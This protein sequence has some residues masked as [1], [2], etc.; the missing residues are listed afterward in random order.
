M[1]SQLREGE[2]HYDELAAL[3][4]IAALSASGSD[5]GALIEDILR[6]VGDLLHADNVLLFTLDEDEK[7]L[8]FYDA[9]SKA[10]RKF[11]ARA[12][13][14]IARVL[15]SRTGELL[16]DLHG[17][18]EGDEELRIMTGARELLA[19]P[20]YS[21]DA[22]LGVLAAIDSRRNAFTEEDL[23]VLSL[24]ADRVAMTMENARLLTTLQRQV[25]ELEG[26]QRLS[27]LLITGDSLEAVV[28]DSIRIF[29]DL[30][31]CEQIAILLY[32][33][34]SDTLVAHEP[35]IGITEEQLTELRVSMSEPS[36]V[37]T[38]FRTNTAL[39]SNDPANDAWVSRRFQELLGMETL[40]VVPL[41]T[42][43]KPLGV[44]KAINSEKGYFSEED[45][46]FGALLGRQVGTILEANL[47][48]ARERALVRKLKE[49]DRTKS[50]FV[51][52]LAHELKGPM[53]TVLGF[54]HTLRQQWDQVDAEKRDRVLEII[55]K[56]VGRL[57]R[58]VND[59]L[60]VA[61]MEAGTLRY[62]LE[63]VSLQEVV[64]SVLMVH[65]SLQSDHAVLDEVPPE[66]P[67]VMADKDRI[68][69]VVIN[70][71][72]NA[73]RYSPERTRV[74]V[75]AEEV[76]EGDARRYVR[77]AVTDEGIGIAPQD[78]ERIFTKFAMLPKPGWTQKG[79]GLGLFITKGIVEA[80]GGHIW[81]ES[82]VGRGSTFYVTLRVAED[83]AS[84]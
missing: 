25:R 6:I 24:V 2:R 26:L 48:R 50:E 36:M 56:E 71:L 8:T 60:D 82:E 81:V 32:D 66:I 53:T 40:L 14:V 3:Y 12:S 42:G 11:P 17:G 52:M 4:Q 84:S 47:A 75:T 55:E 79:T 77:L 20:L 33:E 30:I 18:E 58:L 49:A 45:L 74:T 21:S 28:E 59:L 72:T 1:G 69:Q 9:R 46:Q 27:K 35:A 70:L 68:R 39:L 23:R 76:E 44:L 62:E 38:V 13:G 15:G 34:E 78:A 41:A 19:V 43:P 31:D 51:S 16:N 10:S 61:R 37:G 57:S 65:T 5:R 64:E 73:T 22:V 80:M 29:S 63:P 7:E 67:K 54:S 83:A